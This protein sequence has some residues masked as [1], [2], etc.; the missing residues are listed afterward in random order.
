LRILSTALQ[1]KRYSRLELG[2]SGRGWLTLERTNMRF[3]APAR[4]VFV[5][6]ESCDRD[7]GYM[8]FAIQLDGE[9]EEVRH[10]QEA[11]LEMARANRVAA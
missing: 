8:D 2:R 4:V 6:N 11:M 7:G 9:A 10:A 5:G 3:A 1:E